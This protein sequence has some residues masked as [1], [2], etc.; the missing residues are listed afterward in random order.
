MSEW[1]ENFLMSE[2]LS[3]KGYIHVAAVSVCRKNTLICVSG[4]YIIMQYIRLLTKVVDVIID[5]IEPET[6]LIVVLMMTV[7]FTPN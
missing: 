4:G 1:E 7:F 5:L 3:L 6:T 2:L